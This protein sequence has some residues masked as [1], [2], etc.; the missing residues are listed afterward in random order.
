MLCVYTNIISKEKRG[1]LRK[2]LKIMLTCMEMQDITKV[3][4][5]HSRIELFI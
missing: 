1:N 4:N 3:T 5:K 2:I